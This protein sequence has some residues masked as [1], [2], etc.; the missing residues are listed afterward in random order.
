[1]SESRTLKL[2]VLSGPLDGAPITL[3][4]DAK[5]TCA[6]NGETPLTF[7]WDT[8]LGDPQARFTVDAEEGRW[9]LEGLDAPHGTYR[10]NREERLTGKKVQLKGGDIIKASQTWLL[11]RQA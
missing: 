11:V 2:E 5:W 4:T 8:E 3:E 6:G 1:M 7:P 10:V 9:Y